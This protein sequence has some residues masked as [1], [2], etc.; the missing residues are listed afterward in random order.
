MLLLRQT[1][2]FVEQTDFIGAES[3]PP[4]IYVQ[5]REHRKPLKTTPWNLLP[6][7]WRR[8]LWTAMVPT[9]SGDHTL[10]AAQDGH[11]GQPQEDDDGE[12]DDEVPPSEDDKKKWAIQLHRLHQ[13]SGHPAPRNM[14]RMLVDAQVP[15]W[16]IQMARD[17]H[18]PTCQE[19]RPGGTASKQVPPA[20]VHP[21][22]AAWEC[23]GID[24]GEWTVPDRNLKVKFI[25]MVD[26]ATRYRVTEVL[27]TYKRGERKV[28]SAD[29]VIK[30]LR[31]LM[32]KPR[33]K[34]IIPDNAKSLVSQKLTEF[35]ADLGIEVM[36]PPDNESWAHG[37]TERAIGHIKETASLLQQSLPDRDP[38]LTL[39]IW[40]QGPTTTLS[41]SRATPASNGPTGS[42]PH[43][44]WMN[45]ANSSAFPS[46]ASN[47]SSYD[48]S[49]NENW[50]RTV[51]ARQRPDWYSQS[52]RTHP[53]DSP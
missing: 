45:F 11:S 33:P 27:F 42:K 40:P 26:I 2:S 16:K 3:S 48:F 53:S 28:E 41:M 37:I 39:A 30:T 23:L 38:V 52:S 10:Y 32:D 8:M 36:P 43:G 22:L 12:G 47:K 51:P 29:L 49:T 35:L 6:D 7:R 14:V 19:L 34:T 44:A 31:W 1:C 17:F 4:D 15:Q 46:T 24:V 5:T 50:R 21:A 25:L 20:S 18:C 9:T 13:A